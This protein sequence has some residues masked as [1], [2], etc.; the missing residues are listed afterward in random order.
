M[1]TFLFLWLSL[2]IADAIKA[3]GS[4]MDKFYAYYKIPEGQRKVYDSVYKRISQRRSALSAALK[5]SKQRNEVFEGFTYD[6]TTFEHDVIQSLSKKLTHPL[7]HL[8]YYSYFDLGYGIYGLSLNPKVVNKALVEIE[9]SSAIWAMEPSLLEPIIKAAGGEDKQGRFLKKIVQQNKDAN[10]LS[11]VRYNLSTDRALKKG[12][13]LP[14]FYYKDLVDTTKTLSS[15]NL[16]GKY[17]LI[18]VWATW[19]VPCIEEFPVL[20]SQ[21]KKRNSND[22]EFLSV[23]IDDN[24]E[25]LMKFLKD[26]FPLPWKNMIANSRKELMNALMITGIPCTILIDSQGRI[27]HYGSELRGSNLTKTLSNLN[28]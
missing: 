23:S 22:L 14:T 24:I 15:Q 8:V 16:K 21:Y 6:W 17:Y 25:A 1:K 26:K 28:K 27:L 13:F 12:K 2:W 9:P 20:L 10:L 11:Y 19:C 4:E 18:D 7:K 5:E 3:Q